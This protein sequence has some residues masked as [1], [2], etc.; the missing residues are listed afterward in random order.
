[1]FSKALCITLARSNPS[2]LSMFSIP[3]G[4]AVCMCIE[5]FFCLPSC[6][7]VLMC[8]L[9]FTLFLSVLLIFLKFSVEILCTS[10]CSIGSN[11]FRPTNCIM[12]VS[13]IGFIIIVKIL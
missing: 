1:M 4:A 8:I 6:S 2:S 12:S 11:F 7:Y 9:S 5:Y 10:S 13:V 3:A